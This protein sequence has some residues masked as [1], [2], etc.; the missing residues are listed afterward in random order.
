MF[1]DNFFSKM[2]LGILANFFSYP[3]YVKYTYV[4]ALMSEATLGR[5]HKGGTGS[6]VRIRSSGLE[7]ST[8]IP[9]SDTSSSGIRRNK[10]RTCNRHF[11][12]QIS[13]KS[14]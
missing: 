14:V 7:L 3:F 13:L 12:I 10:L 9:S 4:P 11:L 5:M 6:R 2:N 8:F 1:R